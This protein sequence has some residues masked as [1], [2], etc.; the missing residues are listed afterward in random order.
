[1]SNALERLNAMQPAEAEGELISCCHST[2]WARAV[3]GGRPFAT[4]GEL[5][6]AGREEVA[7]LSWEDVTAALEAHPR[8]GARL[9]GAGREATW[10]RREQVGV[11]AADAPLLAALE[12]VN[13]EYEER[14]GRVLLIFASGLSPAEMM[15][16]ARARLA[17]DEETE[18]EVVRTELGLITGLRLERLVGE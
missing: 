4:V 13:Q 17:N 2:R 3:A 8:I 1:M 6:W 11:D 9:G 15:A 7:A 14:F 10:S 5:V 16:A 18:R 12:A